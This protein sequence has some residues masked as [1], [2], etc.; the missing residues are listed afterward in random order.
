MDGGIFAEGAGLNDDGLCAFGFGELGCVAAGNKG[1]FEDEKF[2][3]HGLGVGGS[4]NFRGKSEAVFVH[5][6]RWV[7]LGECGAF[8]GGKKP[9]A[10]EVG[11]IGAFFLKDG[12]FG[13][14]NLSRS[15]FVDGRLDVTS[16]IKKGGDVA[17]DVTGFRWFEGNLDESAFVGCDNEYL[18]TLEVFVDFA[19]WSVGIGGIEEE[20]ASEFGMNEDGGRVDRVV[21]EDGG[22]DVVELGG[23]P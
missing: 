17:G 15:S 2:A 20:K 18:A 3:A 10:N 5:I 7:K 16:C 22:D 12:T 9:V 1:G 13:D 19:E 6:V 23:G 21:N 8:D 4:Y 11:V 14:G